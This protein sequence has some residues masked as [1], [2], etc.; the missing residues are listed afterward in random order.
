MEN[1]SLL[2]LLA[3]W[4]K[5]LLLGA[6]LGGLA[7]HYVAA[8]ETPTYSADTKL[9]VGPI[10][11]DYDTL[12]AAGDLARSYAEIATSRPVLGYA[13]RKSGAHTTATQ[14]I[15]D[16]KVQTTSNDITR[17]VEITV[18]YNDPKIAAELANGVATRI[19]QIARA[20][21][22]RATDATD[23][24]LRQQ[25]ITALPAQ[26]QQAIGTAAQR[27]LGPSVSGLTT[28][29]DPAEVP[30]DPVSPR[31]GLMTALAAF[32]GFL[33]LGVGVLLRETTGRNI[34]DERSLTALGDP[35]FLGS[36]AAPAPRRG[37]VASLVVDSGPPAV[38]EEYRGVATKAGLFDDP[39]AV[40]SLLVL[41]GSNG[42]RSGAVAANLASVLAHAGRRVV[43]LDANASSDGAT[44]I[45]DLDG[46]PGYGEL[47]ASLRLGGGELNG[48]VDAFRVEHSAD[49]EVLPRGTTEGSVV[50]DAD[51]AQ[52]LLRRLSA[53]ADIVIV[54]AAPLH[55]SPAG[56]VWAR[57]AEG[58]VLVV[59][60]KR[61]PAERIEEVLTNLRLI[62]AEVLGTVI[63]R[64]GRTRGA[65]PGKLA[66]VGQLTA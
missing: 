42:R 8:H 44:S 21:P 10:N 2:P 22:A 17:I 31:V 15:K 6:V 20:T 66:G 35:A 59:D 39:P 40:Q 60:E 28:V 62:R 49:F 53:D 55:E 11:T 63:A 1:K 30:I 12:Q 65:R 38:A 23:A 18:D 29:V 61:I 57:V 27:V 46:R 13:I 4:W 25:E 9:I 5:I 48:E 32:M 37:G 64:G 34:A 33:A 56:L 3:R 24:L 26:T 50:V 14:L 16:G 43:L 19:G 41:D 7:G 51:R 45:L 36:I 54:A 58:A 52:R 47:L